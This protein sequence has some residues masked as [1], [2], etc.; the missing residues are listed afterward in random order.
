MMMSRSKEIT[1]SL[2]ISVVVAI[3][4]ALMTVM[5]YGIYEAIVSLAEYERLQ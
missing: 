3:I 4:A 1:V 5:M 2:A